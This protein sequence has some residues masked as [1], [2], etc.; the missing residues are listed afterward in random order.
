LA[1]SMKALGLMSGTSMDGID[2][3]IIETDGE[4]IGQFGPALS[5]RFNDEQRNLLM[6]AV[7]VA[8]HLKDRQ[9]RPGVLVQAEEFITTAHSK[10]VNEMLNKQGLNPDDI[11]V[12]GFHGQT[13]FHKIGRAHV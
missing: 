6:Q 7:E 11:D 4:T 12:I 5:S 1:R 2:A 8:R 3:A 10:V 9:E 13:V